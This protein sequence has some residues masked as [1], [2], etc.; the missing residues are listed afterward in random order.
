M[1][2]VPTRRAH[3]WL[4]TTSPVGA[5]GLVGGRVKKG[6]HGRGLREAWLSVCVLLELCG[7]RGLEEQGGEE[8]GRGP[9]PL[10]GVGPPPLQGVG[11]PAG[12]IVLPG[13][14]WRALPGSLP[15]WPARERQPGA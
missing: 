5:W 15:R 11:L 14:E 1:D 2:V 3:L 6:L 12:G 9:P 4:V 8:Q 7:E 13:S 10:Q